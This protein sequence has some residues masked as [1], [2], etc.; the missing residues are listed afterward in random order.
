M[1]AISAHPYFVF[2][3][4]RSWPMVDEHHF[5]IQGFQR[6]IAAQFLSEYFGYRELG[7]GVRGVASEFRIPLRLG[8]RE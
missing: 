6:Y 2:E 8:G 7:S 4:S 1:Q 3:L 5:E